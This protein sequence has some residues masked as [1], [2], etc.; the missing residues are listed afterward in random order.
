LK[1]LIKVWRNET[2]A[3][4][5]GNETQEK[6]LKY[7]YIFRQ[8]VTV[9]QLTSASRKSCQI[10][11]DTDVIVGRRNASEILSLSNRGVI[12]FTRKSY[13]SITYGLQLI[14]YQT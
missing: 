2:W 5:C 4:S 10:D 6:L 14:R 8:R 9:D 12:P 3:K 7:R 1:K 13:I 11:L